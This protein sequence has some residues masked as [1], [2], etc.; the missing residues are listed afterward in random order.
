MKKFLLSFGLLMPFLGKAQSFTT[1]TVQ[2]SISSDTHW[3]CDQQYLLRGYVYVTAGATL[4]IDSGTIIRGDL[5]TKGTLII[6][7]GAKIRAL[8]TVTRPIVFTS[9]QPAGSRNYGDWGGVVLCGKSPTNWTA[10]QQQVE[11]GPRSF[12]GGTDVHDNSGELHYVR[13]EFAGVALTPNNEINGLTLCSVG[14]NTAIDHIQVSYSG[15]DAIEWFGGTVNAKYIVAVGSWDDDFD[16]DCGFQG[17]VQFGAVLRDPLNADNSGS[18]AFESDSYQTGTYNGM[19]A[20]NSKMTRPVF[21]N[22]TVVGPMITPTTTS[23]NN[24]YVSAVQIRRGSAL[25]LLNSVIMGWPEGVLIDESSSSFGST[26]ANIASNELQVR[27]N[28]VAGMPVFPTTTTRKDVMYV[29]NGAR[30]LT[31]TTANND[32]T[33][34]AGTWMGTPFA[35]PSSWLWNAPYGNVGFPNASDARLS[36]PFYLLNPNFNPNSTS[37]V[38]YNATHAFNP[39]NPINFDT[40]G[41]YVNYNVPTVVPDFSSTKAN[42]A[43]FTHTNYV[44]G[45]AGTG[46]SS[47]NWMRQ[48]TNFDPN[49]TD[50]E[51]T[52]YVAIDPGA[53]SQ[54]NNATFAAK[55]YPNP[56]KEKATIAIDILETATVKVTL[57]DIAGNVVSVPFNGQ[58]NRGM[59][60][61]DVNTANLA[62]GIYNV[63]I[64]SATKTKTFRLSVIK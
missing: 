52:C 56:A 40:T 64:S 32:T 3:T 16:T 8:G 9:N 15:D 34:T 29:F 53:V 10:G 23:Y 36:N 48:W 33:S 22:I 57:S 20:D 12:Y 50:Y 11:G 46:L 17:K 19:P 1:V 31:S 5:D 39:N 58:L 54:L 24:Q 25:S 26:S 6:E 2:D 18:K 21:S 63:T 62:N 13:I 14:D 61:I 7:R 30:S 45:F 44:G 38:C 47:A 49:N 43:F 37:P 60:N 55:V 28:L 41:G 4:T 59:Q 51:T 42:D 35:G 27:N